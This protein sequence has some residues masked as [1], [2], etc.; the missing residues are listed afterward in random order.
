M[1]TEDA[2]TGESVWLRDAGERPPRRATPLTLERI[3]AAAVSELDAHGAE[4]LTMRRLAQRLD[5]SS[6]ALYWHVKTK[7][8]LLDLA[9]DHII[10][11]VPPPAP[12]LEPRAAIY[13]LL[14]DWHAVMVAHPWSPGFFSRPLLGPNVLARTEYLQAELTSA[15]LSGIDLAC[16]TRL[17][18]NFVIGA[19]M[20]DATWRWL[21][22]PAVLDKARA[23]IADRAHLYPTLTT[24]GFIEAPWS[25]DELFSR[26]VERALE[27]VIPPA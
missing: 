14:L 23:H 5:V 18:V 3:V 11:E 15:G 12:D 24:S 22:N 4:K 7:E 6:T 2:P 8:D 19:A 9:T 13:A 25:D 16:A 21:D 27:T 17:L 26:A 1:T 20:A 10:G